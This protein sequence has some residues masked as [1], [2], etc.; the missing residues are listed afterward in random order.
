[1]QMGITPVPEFC[2][3][4]HFAISEWWTKRTRLHEPTA[5]K[6]ITVEAIWYRPARHSKFN[7][8]KSG[9]KTATDACVIAF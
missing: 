9:A 5:C 2:A 3:D 6:Q 7:P 4:F 8:Q 1:M